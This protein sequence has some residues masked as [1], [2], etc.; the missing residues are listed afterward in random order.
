MDKT[1]LDFDR[2]IDREG[3]AAVKWD[4]RL[5]QFGDPG[6]LPLWVADMDLPAP[7]AVIRSILSYCIRPSSPL[8]MRAELP[9][10]RLYP[11]PR[12]KYFI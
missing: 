1:E 5:A 9:A 2:P 8:I 10:S 6:V 7:A 11:P 12:R 4:A 3:T